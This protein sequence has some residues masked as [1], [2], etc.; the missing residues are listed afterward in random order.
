M[1]QSDFNQHERFFFII[2]K[3]ALTIFF[4]WCTY[5]VSWVLVDWSVNLIEIKKLGVSRWFHILRMWKSCG[6]HISWFMK[7]PEFLPIT[8]NCKKSIAHRDPFEPGVE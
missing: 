7:F 2:S 6:D 1:Q 4:N 5:Q 8:A 3:T